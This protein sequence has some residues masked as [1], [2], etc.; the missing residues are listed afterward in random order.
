MKKVIV[1]LIDKIKERKKIKQ[2]MNKN[3]NYLQ[4]GT[5]RVIGAGKRI[6]YIVSEQTEG[7][8][9]KNKLHMTRESSINTETIGQ[10]LK[11]H[12]SRF[13]KIEFKEGVRTEFAGTLIMFTRSEDM[14]IFD[15]QRKLVTTILEDKNGYYTIKNS[16]DKFREYFSMTILDC[17]DN[18]QA[19][20]ESF[21][22]FTPY[23]QWTNMEVNN[24]LK[25][26]FSNYRDYYASV[27]SD[28]LKTVSATDLFAQFKEKVK[29]EEL[30]YRIGKIL[31]DQSQLEEISWPIVQMHGDLNFN[32]ILLADGEYYFIDW[33]DADEHLLFYDLL[34][35]LFVE[36]AFSDDYR[37]LQNY[38]EGIYDPYFVDIFAEL[39][40][41]FTVTNK[42]YYLVMYICERIVK[43][44]L[45][46]H[47]QIIDVIYDKYLKVLRKIE[48]QNIK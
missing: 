23:R 3:R 25:A 22:D 33:E 46:V 21:L 10:K 1:F 13:T 12:L 9:K 42:Y 39:N 26:I 35:W 6:V 44:E 4:R 27:N 31:L 2:L 5:Y 43:F 40:K 20:T 28:I 14:K 11:Q 30:I 48:E 34:N 16:H 24:G 8:I 38:L 41:D 18:K 32:N 19:Y 47:N 36:A 29:N 17:N 37:F 15:F 7:F 45:E